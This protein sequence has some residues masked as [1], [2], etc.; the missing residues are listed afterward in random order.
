MFLLPYRELV[1]E[2]LFLSSSNTR[3]DKVG[4]RGS[5]A[6]T[7]QFNL[8]KRARSIAVKQ[9]AGYEHMNNENL[10]S[11]RQ[12]YNDLVRAR[13]PEAIERIGWSVEDRKA[14]TNERLGEF[15]EF[16]RAQ[17]PWHGQRLSSIDLNDVTVDDMSQ[18][19]TMN[20]NDLHHN[21]DQ[22]VTDRGLTL[23]AA[24][25]HLAS[26]ATD[27]FSF[28]AGRYVIC[29]TGG[30]TGVRS[31]I[32]LD[33]EGFA[34]WM[35]VNAAHAITCRPADISLPA[36]P[37]Q[38]RLTAQNPMHASGAVSA[39]MKGALAEMVT[40]PPTTPI[41]E[42]VAVLNEAQPDMILGYGSMLHM[43]AAEAIAGRLRIKPQLAGNVGE[44]LLPETR[45]AVNEAFGIGIRN[46]YV[47]TEAYLGESWRGSE[48]IHLSEDTTVI[49][50]VDSE[51]QPVPPGTRSA[52][53]LIT[54]LAN[55]LQPLIRYEIS[56]EIT[57][58]VFDIESGNPSK[59]PPGPWNGRWIEPP[60]GRSDDW[61]TYGR[62][63]VHPHVFRSQLA[64]HHSIA[65]YQVTQTVDGARIAL[66]ATDTVDTATLSG[67]VAA[68]LQ[69]LGLE[70]ASV[71]V[72]TV[73]K[74]ERHPDSG[75]LRRFIG[76]P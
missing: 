9:V 63:V 7:L 31:V 26:F 45:L 30:S 35:A 57:E 50:L 58:A 4:S 1:T 19:P 59:Q 11:V 33:A 10:E 76:L 46:S 27:G 73:P 8:V 43:V 55:R 20:K 42:A 29:A 3:V 32:A 21:W 34:A 44:P 47:A 2:S 15:L 69:R 71:H 67:A 75:K 70:D 28:A 17:S 60:Q 49:E 5:C 65:E 72:E 22:I 54:N 66:V 16:V 18:L 51:N 23:A 38:G 68:E 13:I 41:S 14:F 40:V 52:K 62:T 37:V 12:D 56:D 6:C 61:F 24:N 39:I 64:A 25:R 53:M 36:V 74:I 48:L